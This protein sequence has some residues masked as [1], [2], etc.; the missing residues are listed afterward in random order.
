M[1]LLLVLIDHWVSSISFLCA[2]TDGD[3]TVNK[4]FS[5]VRISYQWKRRRV[6][7][8]TPG[9]YDTQQEPTR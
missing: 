1:Y 8:E 6:C 3:Q 5:A 9:A 2:L 7:S 4:R